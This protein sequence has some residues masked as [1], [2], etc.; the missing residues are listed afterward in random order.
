MRN[1]TALKTE[2]NASI[3][4]LKIFALAL[5][6]V[7]HV[8]QTI[9]STFSYVPFSDYYVNLREVT[10]QF[11]FLALSMLRYCGNLGNTVFFLCSAWFFLDNN[12]VNKKKIF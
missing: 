12:T 4:L 10:D 9:G 1:S 2:R 11:R 6:V 7:G 3:E 8:V 5:I